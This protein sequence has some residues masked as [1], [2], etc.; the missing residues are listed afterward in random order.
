M[1]KVLL[2]TAV[3]CLLLCVSLGAHA[4]QFT[5]NLGDLGG[6]SSSDYSSTPI[7]CPIDFGHWFSSIDS[8]TMYWSAE[9]QTM[10]QTGSYMWWVDV[11]LKNSAADQSYLFLGAGGFGGNFSNQSITN[12]GPISALADGKAVLC[13]QAMDTVPSF[14]THMTSAHIY[15]VSLVLQGTPASAPVP[16]PSSLLALITGV[17]AIGGLALRRRK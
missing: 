13:F 16:E 3:V 1:R 6:T 9:G 17:G 4:E 14:M 7:V 10:S 2:A 8:L 11:T 12:Y 5:L 15:D